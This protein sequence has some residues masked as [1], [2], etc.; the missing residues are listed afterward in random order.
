[1]Q[2]KK[3]IICATLLGCA[4][5][6]PKQ[7]YADDYN[8]MNLHKNDATGTSE[9]IDLNIFTAMTFN[10]GQLTL[11][12]GSTT[13]KTYTLSTLRKLTFTNTSTGIRELDAVQA[14]APVEVYTTTGVHVKSGNADL[15]G[16]PNGIYIVR[17]GKTV[18]KVLKK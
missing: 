18:E 17:T 12:N 3:I 1:M 14:N 9:S 11:R 7:A 2:I 6:F 10:N 8:F 13:V 16:L 15:S 5:A 4:L